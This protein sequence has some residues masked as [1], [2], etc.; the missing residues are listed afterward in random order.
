MTT[1]RE[2]P[3]DRGYGLSLELVVMNVAFIVLV[4]AIVWGVLSRYVTAEPG[5]L[6]RGSVQ[7]R[8]HLSSVFVGACGSSSARQA[9]E[10]SIC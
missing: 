10:A 4:G 3:K 6:G 9:C 1:L 7:H 2:A 8:L 5:D